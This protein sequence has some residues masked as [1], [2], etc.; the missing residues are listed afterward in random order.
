[1]QTSHV[2]RLS[3][4]NIPNCTEAGSL[5]GQS[6]RY[7]ATVPGSSKDL[8]SIMLDGE[9]GQPYRGVRAADEPPV[10]LCHYLPPAQAAVIQSP[11]R[12]SI[13]AAT[14]QKR[15]TSF[16]SQHRRGNRVGSDRA[17]GSHLLREAPSRRRVFHQMWEP[18]TS[19]SWMLLYK[20]GFAF[21]V[22]EMAKD[23]YQRYG[24]EMLLYIC[25][26]LAALGFNPQPIIEDL[27]LQETPMKII[28]RAERRFSD[29]AGID[30]L[31]P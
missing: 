7:I 10:L 6:G 26:L 27:G 24:K 15:L 16:T 29:V 4:F 11:A 8:F 30:S 22:G 25:Q 19:S 23:F 2:P 28:A 17:T 12:R 31:L 5:L 9:A 18:A 1:M 3:G 13:A 14:Y 21:W 20:L